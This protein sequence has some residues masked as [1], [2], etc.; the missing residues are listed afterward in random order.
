M[1]DF[2]LVKILV[3]VPMGLVALCVKIA[4]VQFTVRMAES[5]PCRGTNVNAEMGSMALGATKGNIS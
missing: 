5:A 1:E 2:V 4:L 3:P